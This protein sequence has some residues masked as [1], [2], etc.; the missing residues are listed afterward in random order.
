MK[1]K[2][3]TSAGIAVLISALSI[4][5]VFAA[6]K[7][8]LIVNEK[9]IKT[10]IPLEARKGNVVEASVKDIAD[11]LGASMEWD[12]KEQTVYIQDSRET[13]VEQLENAVSPKDQMEAAEQWAE[14]AKMRNGAL[15]YALLSPELRKKQ[16]SDY[17]EMNWV[18]GGSSPW[19]DSYKITEKKNTQP[20]TYD[21]E[22]NYTM[23]DST[24]AIYYAKENITVKKVCID[25]ENDI[26]KWVIINGNEPSYGT[27]MEEESTVKNN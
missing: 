14:S 24:K 19:V 16:Y 15:R 12:S 22:I 9:E 8:K 6:S 11:A 21:Y 26:E 10:E 5:T 27:P 20:Y 2:W 1:K 18:I 13:Q 3:L 4:G 17:K 25:K 7:I 23:T